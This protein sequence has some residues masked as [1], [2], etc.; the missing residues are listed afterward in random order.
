MIGVLSFAYY[1]YDGWLDCSW[2]PKKKF[3]TILRD[4]KLS[5]AFWY[6]KIFD[7]TK[8]KDTWS[9]SFTGEHNVRTL[10]R[11]CGMYSGARER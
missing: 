4:V 1:D 3:M 10:I 2:N 8:K 7:E 11:S 6:A 5:G 9:C